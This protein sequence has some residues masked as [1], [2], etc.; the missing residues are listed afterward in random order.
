MGRNGGAKW[1]SRLDFAWVHAF[2]PHYILFDVSVVWKYLLFFQ[3][4]Q[5]SFFL[6]S[7]FRRVAYRHGVALM[8]GMEETRLK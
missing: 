6:F 1:A 8:D 7:A 5:A 2:R 4:F 3:H